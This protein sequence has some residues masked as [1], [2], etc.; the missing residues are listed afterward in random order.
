[1][2]LKENKKVS[3][4]VLILIIICQLIYTTYV[5]AEK[6]E[7]VHSDEIWS[8][9]LA[10]SY[11]KPFA[12]MVKDVHI[13]D[14]EDEYL[15][16]CNEWISGDV[17]KEYITVQ[18]G[19][20]FSY[21][22]VYYNQTL[23]HHPPLYY[24]LLHTVS[25]F[26]PNQFSFWYGY[27][28]SCI[29]LVI[30]QIF[31]Y[32]LALLVTKGNKPYMALLVCFLYAAG[33][34]SVSTFIFIRMYSLATAITVMHIYFQF[35]LYY[36]ETFNIKKCIVPIIITGLLGLLSH[37]MFAVVMGTCTACICLWLLFRRKIKKMFI[38][39]F[40]MLGTLGVFF[41]IFPSTITQIF[42]FNSVKS[43][44]PMPVM[45]QFKKF[46]T[47]ITGQNL[48]FTVSIYESA[49][50]SYILAGLVIIIALAIPL[51]FLFRNETWFI[52]FCTNVINK[53]KSAAKKF[54]ANPGS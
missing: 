33:L 8:Y 1:M 15:D 9:G 23:D 38:Y 20:Q 11:Y 54:K 14:Q 19:E 40:S 47:Y 26:F 6:K 5:F 42:K 51:C 12:Y 36:S 28:L 17:L 46:L 21:G 43:K 30:T 35:K 49:T 2:K 24:A 3:I 48:G 34:G 18:N 7:G 45:A 52:K 13:D 53:I 39:G 25:S 50:G 44:A 29:F 27:A 22:S 37:N 10:N 4:F 41:L 31:L 16:N 32:K